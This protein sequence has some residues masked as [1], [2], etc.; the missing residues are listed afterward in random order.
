MIYL[1]NAG[2]RMSNDN[3]D[4]RFIGVRLFH[5]GKLVWYT[6]NVICY[7]GGKLEYSAF[8]IGVDVLTRENVAEDEFFLN[9]D[10]YSFNKEANEPGKNIEEKSDDDDTTY[11]VAIL[12]MSQKS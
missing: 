11:N 10:D 5:G 1:Y 8:M 4:A 7:D 9:D 12:I 6:E 3:E 2:V